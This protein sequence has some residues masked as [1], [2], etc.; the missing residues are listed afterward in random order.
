VVPLILAAMLATV[1]APFVAFLQRHGLGDAASAGVALLTAFGVLVVITLAIV[2]QISALGTNIDHGLGTLQR[3]AHDQPIGLSEPQAAELRAGIVKAVLRVADVLLHGA[4]TLVSTTIGLGLDVIPLVF[5]LF[6]MLQDGETL[7]DWV[8][9]QFPAAQRELGG[10]LGRDSW[11]RL[12]GVV[13]GTAL[14]A[15]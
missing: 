9:R 10:G 6:F 2:R 7:W 8:V 5:L 13:L 4:F 1:L 15:L 14:T 12:G 3:W 11:D